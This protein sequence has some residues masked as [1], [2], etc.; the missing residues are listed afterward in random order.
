VSDDEHE[1]W[2][3]VP[4]DAPPYGQCPD[5]GKPADSFACKVRHINI[6]SG[7]AK[8]AND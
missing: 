8:S 5:C 2:V 4:D 3:D 1:V 7:W 6:N